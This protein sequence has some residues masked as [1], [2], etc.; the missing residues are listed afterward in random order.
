MAEE[1]TSDPSLE[2][3]SKEAKP[4]YIQ[5]SKQNEEVAEM[6][7]ETWGNRSREAVTQMVNSLQ[8]VAKQV[9]AGMEELSEEERPAEIMMWFGIDFHPEAGAVVS[10]SQKKATFSARLMWYPKEKPVVSLRPTPGLIPPANSES[11]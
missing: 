4:I 8:E 2:S 11:S 7:L 10:F 9:V 3:E 6:D 5:F 1:K